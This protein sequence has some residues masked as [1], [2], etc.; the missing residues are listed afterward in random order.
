MAET[1]KAASPAAKHEAEQQPASAASPKT[2]APEKAEGQA[3]QLAP[4][5]QERQPGVESSMATKPIVIHEDYKGS[6]KMD[7]LVAFITGGDSGIGKSVA[8]HYAREGADVAF[9]YLGGG[10]E[11]GGA[12]DEDTDAQDTE[13]MVKAEGKRCLVFKGDAADPAAVSEALAKTMQ[14]YGRIDVV[15]A[16]AAEQRQR[17]EEW[18]DI[19]LESV[20]RTIKTNAEA[21]FL[22][23]QSAVKS[24]LPR[25]GAGTSPAAASSLPPASSRLRAAPIFST[26]RPARGCKPLSCAAWHGASLPTASACRPSRLGPFGRR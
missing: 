1:A 12:P 23:A 14:A 19:P 16:N 20:R 8:L 9:L 17:A 11:G 15:V 18:P 5:E 24:P 26:T 7:G 4:E 2:G 22:L 3:A 25:A 21:Y 6:G 13:A 10:G